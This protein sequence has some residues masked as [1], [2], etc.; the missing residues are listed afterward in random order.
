MSNGGCPFWA[1][2]AVSGH[3]RGRGAPKSQRCPTWLLGRPEPNFV[4]VG[5]V[6]TKNSVSAR[7]ADTEYTDIYSVLIPEACMTSS[8]TMRTMISDTVVARSAQN[9][10][11]KGDRMAFCM[12]FGS[13]LG[14]RQPNCCRVFSSLFPG[15]YGL[16]LS[17]G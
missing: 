14:E 5:G 8:T 6:F 13:F 17:V 2:Y 9:G 11:K 4:V 10:A 1:R 12:V 15:Y 3:L 16:S 7:N